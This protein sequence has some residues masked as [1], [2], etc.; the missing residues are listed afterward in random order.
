MSMCQGCNQEYDVD[1]DI[2][3]EL[4][5]KITPKTGDAGLLCPNCICKRLIKLGMTRVEVI[6]DATEL[7]KTDGK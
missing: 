1:M 3:D 6:V 5:V 2:Q 7:I 4:W